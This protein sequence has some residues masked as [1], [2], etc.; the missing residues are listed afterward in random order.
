MVLLIIVYVIYHRETIWVSQSIKYKTVIQL[1]TLK[2][3]YGYMSTRIIITTMIQ[4][5]SAHT[6]RN[7]AVYI[8]AY[9]KTQTKKAKENINVEKYTKKT[10]MN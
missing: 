3:T 8:H 1:L 2:V 5:V 4:M 10:N 7:C 6:V 9:V